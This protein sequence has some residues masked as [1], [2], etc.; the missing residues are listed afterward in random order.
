MAH[1]GYHEPYEKLSPDTIDKHRAIASLMEELEAGD[2]YAQR[3]DATQDESLKQIL[4]HNRE[5][6][7]EH[8]M[9]I[10]EWIRRHDPEFDA[11]MRTYLFTEG[12][13]VA[14]EKEAEQHEG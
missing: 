7:I 4:A 6:E 10:L 3:I 8:A 1:E 13:I 9:M 11:H 14:L 5:E 2:W 12:N